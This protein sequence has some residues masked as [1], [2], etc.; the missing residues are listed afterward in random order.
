MIYRPSIN[1]GTFNVEACEEHQE[2]GGKMEYLIGFLLSSAVAGLA[3]IVGLD[4]DRAFYPTVLCVIASYYVLFGVMG[5]SRGTLVV[6]IVV[7][8]GFML[9]AILG[10]KRNL[11]LVVTAI[12]GHGVFDFVHHFFIQNPGVPPWWP[13]FCLAF[14]VSFGAWLAVRLMRHQAAAL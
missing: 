13:G 5:A 2:Q 10:Y 7:A 11:W 3:A 8:G 9:F 14:D 6:E 12:V 4:R 1:R